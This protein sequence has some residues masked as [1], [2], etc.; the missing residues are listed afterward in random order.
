METLTDYHRR[1]TAHVTPADAFEKIGQVDKWWA[2]DFEGCAAGLND[3]FTVHFGET[4]VTFRISEVFPGKKIV[5]QVTDCYLH[6]LKD[7]KE[8]KGTEIT[9]NVEPHGHATQITMTH[10]GLVPEKECY[11][12]CEKGWNFFVGES[13]LKLLTEQKGLP[14]TPKAAR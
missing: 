8:W 12:N 11:E 14:Q 13:L 2:T 5:W 4:F 6:W 10:V 7:K 9:W 3:V 1:I